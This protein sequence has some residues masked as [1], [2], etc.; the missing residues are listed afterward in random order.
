[1]AVIYRHP[2][3]TTSLHLTG[4]I[5]EV[6]LCSSGIGK[7]AKSVTLRFCDWHRSSFIGW[8]TEKSFDDSWANI[9]CHVYG[10]TNSLMNIREYSLGNKCKQGVFLLIEK[11]N[12]NFHAMLLLEAA[13]NLF[14][15]GANCDHCEK[16]ISICPRSY[17][18]FLL[19]AYLLGCA[20][21]QYLTR[22]VKR[23]R[24]GQP[25]KSQYAFI[26]VL[27][28]GT[29]RGEF[30]HSCS[31]KTKIMT[32]GTGSWWKNTNHQWFASF[33]LLKSLLSWQQT[34]GVAPQANQ[35]QL[36]Q[37]RCLLAMLEGQQRVAW[38]SGSS[39]S[40]VDSEVHLQHD[41]QARMGSCWESFLCRGWSWKHHVT[42]CIEM[43]TARQPVDNQARGARSGQQPSLL[44]EGSHT[45][46]MFHW[47]A[48]LSTEC[49]R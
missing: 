44:Q 12:G 4:V 18:D 35:K 24:N 19:S 37:G 36:L 17:Y 1:M 41:V 49:W 8:W 16:I 45:Q 40:S 10:K 34:T 26:T 22:N 20:R 48:F 30:G 6:P 31:C 27:T 21:H 11:L 14:W 39:Q 29:R 15:S 9:Y 43:E 33:L 28:W 42:P 2:L 47:L 5:K 38:P 13:L 23:R 3:P 7:T 25:P 46:I 32:I